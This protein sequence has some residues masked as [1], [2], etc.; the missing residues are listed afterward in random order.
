MKHVITGL[1]LVIIF[2]CNKPA[3]D[4]KEKLEQLADRT[5]RAIGIRQ[6]R[7]T[8]ANQIRFTQDT[9]SATKSK[10]DSD[11]LQKRL[12]IYFK[13]KDVL[14]KESLALAD[15][16]R[17]QLDSVMPYSNKTAQNHF[18]A[19]LDSLLAKKGCLKDNKTGNFN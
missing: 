8:L 19:S 7:F 13:E 17:L 14:L 1:L 5:C 4:K 15:T 2:S 18:T 12:A 10:A 11:R 6:Q 3:S 16:I 9:L